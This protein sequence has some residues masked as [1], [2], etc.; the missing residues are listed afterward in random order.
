[1]CINAKLLCWCTTGVYWFVVW[2]RYWPRSARSLSADAFN[3]CYANVNKT[4]VYIL[5][6]TLSKK[7][8]W[9]NE[10]IPCSWCCKVKSLVNEWKFSHWASNILIHWLKIQ[11][12]NKEFTL[13]HRD[14]GISSV[15]QWFLLRVHLHLSDEL[16]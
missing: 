14:Q 3:G 16:N 15:I 12:L 2:P 4:F 8:H 1:M 7:N 5:K 13:Q 10:E 9:M 11:S 6:S